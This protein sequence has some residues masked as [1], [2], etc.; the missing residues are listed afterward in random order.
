MRASPLADRGFPDLK[1]LPIEA[2]AI[3]AEVVLDLVYGSQETQLIAA[4]R[5]AGAVTVDGLDILVHQGAA[6]LRIWTG[7]EPPIATMRS[8][9]REV[10][11]S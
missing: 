3:K 8:A 9:A 2:D 7:L 6:S 11:E 1:A 5:A 10:Y 4:A